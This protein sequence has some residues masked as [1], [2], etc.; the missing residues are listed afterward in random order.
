MALKFVWDYAVY[1]GFPALLYFRGKLTDVSFIQSQ[2]KGVEEIRDMNLKMQDFFRKWY[3]ADPTVNANGA[4]V[5]QS[6]IEIMT[7]LN[8]ELREELDDAALKVRFQENVDLIRELMY[9]I[10]Q[11]VQQTQ[12]EVSID[13]PARGETEHHLE[14]VFELLSI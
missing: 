6:Q 9:E 7:R 11:R 1:W 5:D 10:T 12:P 3:D 2:S 4:F 13:I 8:A 14:H